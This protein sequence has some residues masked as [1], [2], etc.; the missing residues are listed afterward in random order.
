MSARQDRLAV[1]LGANRRRV[2]AGIHNGRLRELRELLCF[3]D[4]PRVDAAFRG[5][6]HEES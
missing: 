4:D 6:S 1:D 5:G 2:L 3:P